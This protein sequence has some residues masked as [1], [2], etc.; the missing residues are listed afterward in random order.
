MPAVQLKDSRRSLAF[1][2]NEKIHVSWPIAG[3]AIQS[4]LP[5]WIPLKRITRSNGYQQAAKQ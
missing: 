5:I 1:L 4:N 3:L 2:E